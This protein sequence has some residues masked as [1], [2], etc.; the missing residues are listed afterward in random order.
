MQVLSVFQRY[1]PN[2]A[3]MIYVII[4]KNPFKKFLDLYPDA[5]D[6]LNLTSSSFYTGSSPIKLS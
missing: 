1:E 5:E 4:L 3:K 2:C 6:L